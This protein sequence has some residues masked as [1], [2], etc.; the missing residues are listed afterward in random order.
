MLSAPTELTDR[1]TGAHRSFICLRSQRIPRPY[2]AIVQLVRAR[3][4]TCM[5]FDY[6]T[7]CATT[8]GH[9]LIH[10]VGVRNLVQSGPRRPHSTCTDRVIS[11]TNPKEQKYK[12]T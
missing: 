5:T 8:F 6:F 10:A 7:A 3:F 11:R 2:I 1:G 4:C 9:D 12:N